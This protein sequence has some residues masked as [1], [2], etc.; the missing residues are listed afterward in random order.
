M[1]RVSERSGGSRNSPRRPAA[2]L[3][4]T[5]GLTLVETLIASGLFA[6]LLASIVTVMITSWRTQVFTASSY[7][8]EDLAR[9]TMVKLVHGDYTQQMPVP[10]L[11]RAS[12]V[13]TS[14]SPY[15]AVAYRVTWTDP[16]GSPHDDEICWY[17]DG[18]TLYRVVQPYSAPLDITGSGGT[19]IAPGVVYFSAT[20]DV[21][22]VR[23]ILKVQDQG[24]ATYR[25]RTQ[26]TPRLVGGG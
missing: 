11:I 10:G 13:L 23:I 6:L 24:G 12:A 14:S 17:L 3:G 7:R 9:D 20:L 25:L 5:A 26:V 18:T 4:G 21:S 1:T 15:P 8:A 2:H 19:A 22:L 16:Q